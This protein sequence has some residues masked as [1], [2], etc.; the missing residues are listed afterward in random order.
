MNPS[1][2]ARTAGVVA[3]AALSEL[4]SAQLASSTKDAS[5]PQR[6]APVIQVGLDLIRIDVSVTDKKGRPV[7]DLRPEDFR[8]L[9]DG[10]PQPIANSAFFG[11]QAAPGVDAEVGAAATIR[12]GRERSLVFLIDDLNMSFASVYGA[13]RALKAFASGWDSEEAM[14]GVRL[15]SDEGE[16]V[17]LSR[18]PARFDTSI[19]AFRYNIMSDKGISSANAFMDVTMPMPG[20]NPALVR[21]NF[22]QRIYSLVTTINSLRSV[23]GRKAVIFV[24]EGLTVTAHRDD[25]GIDS[26]FDAIFDDSSVDAALRMIVEVANRASVVVYTMDPS[27]L[28]SDSPDA[29]V[30][31]APAFGSRTLTSLG[32]MDIQ[33]TL[34]RLAADTGGLSVFNRND[35]KRGLADVVDDQRAFYLVGFEPPDSAFSRSSSGKPKFHKIKLSVNRPDVRVRTR[36]GFYGVTDEDVLKRAPLMSLPT[37]P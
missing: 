30:A 33:G 23:P 31:R 4:S 15:T 32:R 34:A 16:K 1:N 20:P 18:N 27:G 6:P 10:K 17:L 35:L 29:S 21:A 7:T 3:L 2:F 25:L 37:T 22:Q 36:A 26:P 5:T 13:R 14:I 24:S 28:V 11:G 8:L 19:E 9:V 12:S